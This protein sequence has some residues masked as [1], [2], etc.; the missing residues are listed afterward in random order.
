MRIISLLLL[1]LYTV[2]AQSKQAVGIDAQG[3]TDSVGITLTGE[4]L[5]D[6]VKEANSLMKK[7]ELN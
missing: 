7:G 6:L 3:N 5:H 4:Q 2:H 1:V